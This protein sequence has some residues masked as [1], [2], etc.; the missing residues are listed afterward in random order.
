ME[1]SASSWSSMMTAAK[2]PSSPPNTL[3]FLSDSHKRSGGVNG[4]RLNFL[5]VKNKR[6]GL[7]AKFWRGGSSNARR[8]L[9]SATSG[10]FRLMS[11]MSILD[12]QS[13]RA[14]PKIRI[15]GE[16]FFSADNPGFQVTSV[17]LNCLNSSAA[18]QRAA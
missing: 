2:I 4:R 1:L 15:R 13:H 16:Y 3:C 14:K 5:T 17:Y 9:N 12:Q 8:V 11:K 10:A 18:A 7:R 6:K